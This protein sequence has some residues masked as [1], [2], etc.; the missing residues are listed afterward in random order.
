[1]QQ[2]IDELTQKL[3]ETEEVYGQLLA[4]ENEKQNAILKRQPDRVIEMLEQERDLVERAGALEAAVLNRRDEIGE[5]MGDL[6]ASGGEPV[7]LKEI[8]AALDA[9]QGQPLE[10]KRFRLMNL[11]TA[12]RHVSQ[13]NLLLLKQS[14]ELLD[15]IISS[16]MG[17]TS[18]CRTYGASGA[19]PVRAEAAGSMINLVAGD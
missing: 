4:L 7:T 1:M 2:Q 11:A 3:D 14:A 17:E 13:T 10:D 8:A 12:L 9:P 16:A 19:A 6:P 18:K 15:Q 5:R